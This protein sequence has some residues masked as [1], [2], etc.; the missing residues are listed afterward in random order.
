[1][2]HASQQ[3]GDLRVRKQ[4]KQRHALEDLRIQRKLC[5][6]VTPPRVLVLYHVAGRRRANQPIVCQIKRLA[7]RYSGTVESGQLGVALLRSKM[8]RLYAEVFPWL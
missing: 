6:H 1:M 4:G 5:R 7:S 3:L 8:N 2:L